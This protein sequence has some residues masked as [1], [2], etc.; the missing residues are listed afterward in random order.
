MLLRKVEAGD[1]G[2][3]AAFGFVYQSLRSKFTRQRRSPLGLTVPAETIRSVWRLGRRTNIAGVE[4]YHLGRLELLR[5]N[6]KSRFQYLGRTWPKNVLFAEVQWGKAYANPERHN[7][8][9]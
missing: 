8:H 3:S 1:C 9:I 6:P 4:R 7:S 2:G 5:G